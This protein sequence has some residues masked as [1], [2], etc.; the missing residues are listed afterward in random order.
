METDPS[1]TQMVELIDEDPKIVINYI[2]Y[3]QEARGKVACVRQ[4]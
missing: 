3:V 1:I 2:A 4:I